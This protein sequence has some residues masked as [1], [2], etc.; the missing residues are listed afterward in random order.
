MKQRCWEKK[1]GHTTWEQRGA[2]ANA[3]DTTN[4]RMPISEGMFKDQRKKDIVGSTN[5]F[6]WKFCTVDGSFHGGASNFDFH[7]TTWKLP[8]KEVHGRF[9]H[10]ATEVIEA[11]MVGG[12]S[13]HGRSGSF[14]ERNGS[15]QFQGIQTVDA[16]VK[17]PIGTS[18]DASCIYFHWLSR[19]S[20]DFHRDIPGTLL[21]R[22]IVCTT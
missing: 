13:F 20:I 5:I 3:G 8:W 19:T 21:P 15:F 17:I 2:G 1:E 18:T 14:H 4:T 16:S 6:L 22:R 9:Y 10:F 7:G 12:G 11:S